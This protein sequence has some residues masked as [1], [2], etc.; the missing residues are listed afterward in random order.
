SECPGNAAY[1]LLPGIAKLVSLTGL[2]K[3]YAPVVSGALGGNVR[4][5]ARL[6]T[7]LPWTITVADAAGKQLARKTGRS[8]VVDWTWSSAGVGKGPFA[9]SI[10][11]GS[12]VF[13][14]R[15][16]LGGSLPSV[17]APTPAPSPAPAP[18]LL[19]GL[20][21]T[22]SVLTLNADGTGLLTNVDFTLA[23]QAQV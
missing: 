3:L 5:Q 18:A 12:D 6:S 11:A 2:P 7:S 13:P 22:P 15:G 10:A 9:W 17:S 4:F 16:T 1:A 14:A 20:T 21:A 23:Q 8:Q 19:T